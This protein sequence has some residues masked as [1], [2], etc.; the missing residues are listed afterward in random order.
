MRV[1]KA[2]Q[3]GRSTLGALLATALLTAPC[4][5]MT[6]VPAGYLGPEVTAPAAD[7]VC[8][9]GAQI[10]DISGVTVPARAQLVAKYSAD[11][12]DLAGG[13]ILVTAVLAGSPGEAAGLRRGDVIRSVNGVSA[14]HAADFLSDLRQ[15]GAAG[16]CELGVLRHGRSTTLTVRLSPAVASLTAPAVNGPNET[17]LRNAASTGDLATVRS[18]LAA[19]ANVNAAN[20]EGDTPLMDAAKNDHLDVVKVL[21]GAHADMSLHD[22]SAYTALTYAA[23]YGHADV[24]RALL[25]HGALVDEPGGDGTTALALAAEEGYVDAAKI[26]LAHGANIDAKNSKGETPLLLAAFFGHPR[27]ARWLVARGADITVRD[28]PFVT[29]LMLAAAL[30]D[31]PRAS[32][33]IAQ[34][35]EVNATGANGKTAL[36]FAS[37][38][39]SLG[40]LNLLLQQGAYVGATDTYI[41]DPYNAL[42]FA[43]NRK[44]AAALI[45]HGADVNAARPAVA[46]TDLGGGTALMDART[47]GVAEELLA[48]GARIDARAT[49]GSMAIQMAIY[50]RPGV[51]EVLLAHGAEIDPKDSFGNTPLADAVSQGKRAVAL[52][53]AAYG[54]DTQS[55]KAALGTDAKTHP[56]LVA[57]LTGDPAAV[58]SS[59]QAWV[60]E[61]RVKQ[62]LAATHA[63]RSALRWVQTRL[64]TDPEIQSWRW[65]AIRIAARLRPAPPIPETA[66]EHLARGVAAFKLA[67]D[68]Q[69]LK[70]AS[71]EFRQAVALAPWWPDPYYDLAKTEEKRGAAARAALDY[72]DYLLAAPH[73]RDAEDVRSKIYQLQYVA[74]HDQAA[75]NALAIRQNN[76][77]QI[78]SWLQDHY[79]KA[80]LASYVACNRAGNYGTMRCSD[81]DAK[82]SNWY[83]RGP[84]SQAEVSYWQ[85][86]TLQ[87]TVGGKDADEVHLTLPHSSNSYCGTV[88][89]STNLDTVTWTNCTSPDPVWISFGTSNQNTPWFEIK[90]QCIPD[91]A[92]PS[93][94]D[95]CVRNDYT[96]Q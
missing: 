70:P 48:H 17:A 92:A 91:P 54:A 62:A 84:L 13:P 28:D 55:I 67:T 69:G 5:A 16:H 4:G 11:P 49:D 10:M 14:V 96:L 89:S 19:G 83:G 56:R 73:A 95:F 52:T 31:V 35:A 78:A 42:F 66:R 37:Q 88:G 24:V 40:V 32:A 77:R 53:L 63:P 41:G 50:G 44:I 75:A 36:M 3:V 51:V 29:P 45:A 61:R 2:L 47:P 15:A 82:Q 7:Q 90:S 85:G 71:E 86:G 26:L 58:Q 1:F 20:P 22:N 79:G 64:Q 6:P 59:A 30:D 9:L 72:E 33:L 34:G 74:A 8:H 60:T 94:D 39:G 27:T 68:P 18:L 38:C 43:A 81:A 23:M 57:S 46:G 80:T 12:L 76:A 25:A 93:E 65:A 87:F 21:L